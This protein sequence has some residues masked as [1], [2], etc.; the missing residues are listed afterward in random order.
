MGEDRLRLERKAF[1]DCLGLPSPRQWNTVRRF[2]P[3]PPVLPHREDPCE[4]RR[5]V[6]NDPLVDIMPNITRDDLLFPTLDAEQIECCRRFGEERRLD[7]GEFLFREGDPENDFYVIVEGDL[8]VTKRV[9]GEDALLVVHHAGQFT[10]AL[11]MFTRAA[12]IATGIA[13]TPC[14][15]IHID[16]ESFKLLL[17]D[18]P[19]VAVRI[20]TAMAERR[21][22]AISF[23]Q[24]REKLAALGKL[25]AGLAHELNNPAAAAR[26]AVDQLR[27]TFSALQPLT[28]A[29]GE[30]CLSRDQRDLLGEF[31]KRLIEGMAG[32]ER[33][34]PL[35]QSD[36]EDAMAEW[37]ES[38]GFE[39][40]WDV[41]PVLVD[42]G[43][44]A[45]QLDQLNE[46]F[47]QAS[48]PTVVG[49]LIKS[50]SAA[51]LLQEIEQS[52]SRIA[53]LVKA[54]KSYSYMDQAPQQEI[55]VHEGLDSTLTILGHKLKQGV[56]VVREYDR[57]LPRI[58]AYGSEL[59]QVWTNLIDNAIDAMGGRGRLTVRTAREDDC[60]L[61]EI[62]DD[63]PGISDE[64][65]CRLFEP[66]FTTKGVGQGTGLGLDTSRK[67]VVDR[68][69]GDIR[70]VSE[71]GDTRFQ[72]YLPI[73]KPKA[74]L[75]GC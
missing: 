24:Q 70:V 46:H 21:P 11:S 22:E 51:G 12:S 17:G 33:L 49:W 8:K 28:L 73:T 44:D 52:T 35:A 72:V 15:V 63:G 66:F 60:L 34:D 61:V 56:T 53:D 6:P 54:V 41:A 20:L 2:A 67:I 75:S 18:C 45:P 64:T 58:P 68:H 40:A 25:S 29:L 10:G 14:R 7:T 74:G 55:D 38:H 27:Y 37:L 26:R 30:L 23:T 16:I 65:Q 13:L 69:H 57:T 36:Q 42:A 62:G 4:A 32:R 50:L 47:T 9:A 43:L 39:K 31:E 5:W 19:P 3:H 59:N 48:L 71:P 1:L